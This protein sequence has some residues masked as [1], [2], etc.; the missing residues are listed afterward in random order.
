MLRSVSDLPQHNT[1]T[2]SLEEFIFIGIHGQH[3]FTVRV[4]FQRGVDPVHKSKPLLLWTKTQRTRSHKYSTYYK[5]C[6][7]ILD[8]VLPY[9]SLKYLAVVDFKIKIWQST[10][11]LYY[12]HLKPLL[13]LANSKPVG[14]VVQCNYMKS[15]QWF[16]WSSESRGV[17]TW[18][19][20]L[21]ARTGELRC[22]ADGQYTLF[23]VDGL[24]EALSNVT[25][26]QLL[27]DLCR[28]K[29]PW[30]SF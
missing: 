7:G 10:Q 6:Y 30:Y 22:T 3:M 17:F 18:E 24:P 13:Y 5:V 29:G 14:S 16:V 19:G 4:L 12:Y 11:S 26:L 28:H 23:P 27:K 2:Y 21:C 25:A 8:L 15:K 20:V 1:V 9:H